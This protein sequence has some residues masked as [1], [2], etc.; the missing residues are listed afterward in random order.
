[1]QKNALEILKEIE[2]HG[3]EAYIVGGFVRDYCLGQTSLDID[4]CTNATPKELSLIFKGAIVPTETYGAVT[5][6]YKKTRYE[7]TTYR[8]DLKYDD[9]RRPSQIEYVDSLIE[10]LKRRDFTINTLC[11]NSKGEVI[12][13]LNA[14]SDLEQKII[15]TVGNP[16]IR[17]KEDVLRILR[18]VRFATSLDFELSDDVKQAIID[19]KNLLKNL[20]YVR[21]KEELTKILSNPNAIYGVSLLKSLGLDKSLELTNLSNLKIVD[22]ILGIWAQLDVLD[23]YP[24][25]NV[26]RDAITKIKEALEE[27]NIDNYSLYK[28]GLYIMIIVASIKELDKKNLTK[29]YASLPIKARSDIKLDVDQICKRLNIKPSYWIKDIYQLLEKEITNGTLKNSQSDI[30]EYIS[31]HLKQYQ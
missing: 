15:K 7:I 24:F 26:E 13:L 3:Y 16:K 12:D 5:L 30:C 29:R 17:F 18:A 10:D 20:S 23:I 8:K 6:I 19:N 21:K 27:P 31:S 2:K 11:M 4:V 25:S 14:K 22:D 1:M 9:Y 28:Y